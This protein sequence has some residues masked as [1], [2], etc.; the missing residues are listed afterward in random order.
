MV[1]LQL[2][3][4]STL[5][6]GCLTSGESDE[7]NLTGDNPGAGDN[8]PPTISG[9]PP[10]AV[11]V[12]ESYSFTPVAS[13]PDGDQLTFSIQ[14][15]PSWAS[16]D[17][18]TGRLSGMAT[19][20]TEGI[21]SNIRISVSDGTTSTPLPQFAVN[22]T[23]VSLGQATLSWNPPT[24]NDDGSSL[25]DLAA[26]RIY[27][28]TS[29]GVYPNQIYIDNPGITTYVVENLPP[30]TYYFVSTAINASGIES[31]FSNV[32]TKTIN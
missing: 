12:G 28:G 32:A 14:N 27:Y 17:P 9:T 16:F 5:L 11:T 21:Y 13:D 24:Q 2:A 22:V 1:V 3:A 25:T 4:A 8:N 19:L 15:Q 31:G 30:S 18:S 29:A 7:P 20:G 26:Y 23:L 6:S 10:P